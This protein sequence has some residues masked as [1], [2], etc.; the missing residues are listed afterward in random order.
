[1]AGAFCCGEAWVSE[2]AR[3][4][5]GVMAAYARGGRTRVIWLTL[6]TPKSGFVRRSFPAVNRAIRRAAATLRRDVGIL[7][8]I[9]RFSP[10]GRYRQWIRVRGEE[11]GV[12]QSDG[13]H[14]SDHGAAIAASMVV[15]RLRRERIVR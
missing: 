5:H 2:Y 9:K 7:D 14:L 13:I 10:G 6:P 15:Q 1:M 11:V 8:M 12:R 4:V 3:R